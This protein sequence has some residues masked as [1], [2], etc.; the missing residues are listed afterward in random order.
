MESSLIVQ[1]LQFKVAYQLID[2]TAEIQTK[3]KIAVS[4]VIK[5]NASQIILSF[6]EAD[7]LRQTGRVQQKITIVSVGL[8]DF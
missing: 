8:K 3:M 4:N 5:L 7:F 2:I 1:I 6:A